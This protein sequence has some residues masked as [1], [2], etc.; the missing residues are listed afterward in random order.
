MGLTFAPAATVVLSAVRREEHGKAS[1]ANSTAREV[2]GVLGVAVL[3]TVFAAYGGYTSPQD[4][5]DGVRPA[6]WIGAAVTAL[7]G[8]VAF[9]IP[10]QPARG[11]E[12][13]AGGAGPAAPDVREVERAA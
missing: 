7:G 13:E 10:R 9:A 8:L 2:G 6:L 12:P 11:P 5:V 1:G 4:F 3:G